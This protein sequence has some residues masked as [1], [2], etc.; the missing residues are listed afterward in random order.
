[1]HESHTNL[2][3]IYIYILSIYMLLFSL[4]YSFFHYILKLPKCAKKTLHI[5]KMF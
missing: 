3:Y 1:M 2:P 4:F 5:L